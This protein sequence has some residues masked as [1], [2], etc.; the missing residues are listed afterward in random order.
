MCYIFESGGLR[1]LNMTSPCFNW[2]PSQPIP[3][4][5]QLVPN[6]NSGQFDEAYRGPLGTN[7]HFSQPI[8]PWWAR[9]H[10]S[11]SSVWIKS[12]S[13]NITSWPK[14]EESCA[15]PSVPW[16]LPP[17]PT[18][19]VPWY[20][21][22]PASPET[23][24][25]ASKV[26]WDQNQSKLTTRPHCSGGFTS[27]HVPMFL[28]LKTVLIDCKLRF[29][30]LRPRNTFETCFGRTSGKI[31]VDSR[32]LIQ[33]ELVLWPCMLVS[34]STLRLDAKQSI[35][36]IQ[37]VP[38]FYLLPLLLLLLFQLVSLPLGFT[39]NQ[40]EQPVWFWKWRA[41][42]VSRALPGNSAS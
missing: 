39:L 37:P 10:D 38:P 31:S 14:W 19:S 11:T 13:Y 22:H 25:Y 9:S 7:R 8:S 26:C 6:P 33:V 5:V 16:S 41:S 32:W 23:C 2:S 12:E 20:Q 3:I 15:P 36:P 35:S 17:P 1:M 29:L 21:L 28:L 40:T 30:Q 34:Q 18:P 24:C 4:P 42:A 27:L